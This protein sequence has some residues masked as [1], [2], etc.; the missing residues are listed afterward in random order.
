MWRR[1]ATGSKPS[2]ER[3]TV[4]SSRT[5]HT[6]WCRGWDSLYRL[7]AGFEHDLL[8]AHPGLWPVGPGLPREKFAC[9]L[10]TNNRSTEGYLEPGH[11]TVRQYSARV[12][13]THMNMQYNSEL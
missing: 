12:A 6:L 7:G 8:G 2:C 13:S 10:Q 5:D 9:R 4:R 3:K 1:C 11:F